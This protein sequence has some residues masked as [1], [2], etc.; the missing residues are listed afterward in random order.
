MMRFPTCK[1]CTNKS[2]ADQSYTRC[3]GCGLLTT[4]QDA[5]SHENKVREEADQPNILFSFRFTS[6]HDTTQPQ[7]P[8][9]G[10]GVV[11]GLAGSSGGS[12]A[13]CLI[14]S[15]SRS[16]IMTFVCASS[17][18]LTTWYLGLPVG[19]WVGGWE[20]MWCVRGGWCRC[21]QVK[22][23]CW[24]GRGLVRTGKGHCRPSKARRTKRWA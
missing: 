20:K 19:E 15:I 16:N 4:P 10:G 18:S 17:N 7:P 9:G 6:H 12:V 11:A 8:D 24:A 14:P 22:C 5:F 23:A 3:C 1:K 2:Q 13:R 21:C